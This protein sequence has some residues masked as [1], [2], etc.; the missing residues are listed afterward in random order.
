MFYTVSGIMETKNRSGTEMKRYAAVLFFVA[1]VAAVCVF[2]ACSGREGSRKKPNAILISIDTLRWDHCSVYG[3]KWDTTPT[4][5]A[6]A[7]CG[8]LF[9]SAYAPTS[10]TCPSH[11]TMFTSLYPITHGILLNN[12]SR[13]SPKFETLA[14]R[15]RTKGYQTAGIVSSFVLHSKFGFSQGFEFYED[16]LDKADASTQRPTYHGN[17]VPGGFDQV[18]KAATEKTIKWLS[19][20]R[21]AEKPFFLFV[22]FMDPHGPYRPPEPYASRFPA[23]ILGKYAKEMTALGGIGEYDGEVAYVDD[24]IKKI[25]EELRRLELDKDTLVVIVADHGE[26]LWQRQGY[27]GHG[28]HLYDEGVRVP[29]IF[30][31]PGHILEGRVFP[32]PVDLLTLAPT[33]LD[34]VGVK[35]KGTQF[36]GKSLKDAVCK[37]IAP[38]AEYPIYMQSRDYGIPKSGI[39]VGDW[40][41]IE[42]FLGRKKELYNLKNDP[43]ELVN[44]YGSFPEKGNKFATQLREWMWKYTLESPQE[45]IL[46]EED[47]LKFQSLGYLK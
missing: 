24:S 20:Q 25:Y 44:L 21:K 31:W 1:C 36:L 16:N 41:Y 28:L 13:L 37:G 38:E 39:R 7:K 33:I 19:E 12:G 5:R 42:D 14:E 40:K 27:R 46:S 29:L 8:V 34:L 22:H 6:F 23:E 9:E 32:E 47:R 17:K 18:A 45:P 4:L 26:G 15:F 35:R 10:S 30:Y 11:A 43:K 3:Y 2:W